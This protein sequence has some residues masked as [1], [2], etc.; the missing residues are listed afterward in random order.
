MLRKRIAF[1]VSHPAHLLTVAGMVSRWRP[2]VLLLTRA[3]A[4]QGAGQG[5]LIRAGLEMIGLGNQIHDLWIDEAESYRAALAGD[6]A[7]HMSAAPRILDWIN[8]VRPDAVFGDAFEL[9]NYQHDVGRVLL[10]AVVKRARQLG[11][12]VTNY[13]FPLSCRLA[14]D[15]APLQFG[16]FPSGRYNQFRLSREEL[17]AKTRIVDWAIRLNKFVA[18]VAPLFPGPGVER[19][20]RVPLDRDYTVPPQELA[21]HYDDRGREEVAAGRYTHPISFEAHFQP[22]VRF[23]ASHGWGVDPVSPSR[24]ADPGRLSRR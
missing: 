7:F 20:R 12:D 17:T 13:E 22:L 1:V 11:F 5:E 19:F 8:E 18:D 14:R 6:F 10:D 24:E 16:V 15:G 9:T 2:H 3:D 23:L 21:R 4:G